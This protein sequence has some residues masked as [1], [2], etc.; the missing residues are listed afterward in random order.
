MT[1]AEKDVY[2]FDKSQSKMFP[3]GRFAWIADCLLGDIRTFLDGAN[4]YV[5]N[6]GTLQGRGGG[7]ISIPALASIAIELVS[8]LYMG[9]TSYRD[10]N[11]YSATDNVRSFISRFVPGLYQKIPL[12]VWDGIRNGILH[13]FSP[14]P[15]DYQG[16]NVRFQFFVE[17]YAAKSHVTELNNTI[18]IRI[19]VFELYEVL[20][21]A[22]ENYRKELKTDDSVKNNFI[23]AWL[24]I[25]EY[26]RNI[27]SDVEKS[28]EVE[29]LL[30]EL[31]K[32]NNPLPLKRS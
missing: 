29:A 7:N 15:F 12:L 19:N 21:T 6:K 28:R 27:D 2:I 20:K 5:Q 4:N 22:I 31:N 10:G 17:D 18:L 16:K 3:G 11:L 13:T 30:S 23:R 9:K 14:K 26:S 32:S 25:E 1:P 24:S 8:A